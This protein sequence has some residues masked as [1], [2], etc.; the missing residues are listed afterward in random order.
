MEDTGLICDTAT[1]QPIR[2]HADY[3]DGDEAD[4]TL[5]LLSYREGEPALVAI[6][7]DG[8]YPPE[9]ISVNLSGYGFPSSA[10]VFWTNPN[11]PTLT[12]TL[13]ATR[14][15]EP[16]DSLPTAHYGLGGRET[17]TALRLLDTE[18]RAFAEPDQPLAGLRK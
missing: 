3:G 11:T 5:A 13:L 12:R 8:D 15:A 17:S 18:L 7:D 14:H 16:E 6:P 1:H 4:Y 9:P 10:T 2:L